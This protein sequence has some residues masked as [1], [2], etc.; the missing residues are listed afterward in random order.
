MGEFDAILRFSGRYPKIGDDAAVLDGGLLAATDVVVEA[1]HF[2]AGA[3]LDDVGWHAITVNVSDIAAMGGRA[4][5]VLVAVAGPAATDLDQL[6][7]GV[8]EACAEYGCE[9]AGG[10]LS[11]ADQLV[12]AVCALGYCDE[13]TTPVLRSGARSGDLVWVSGPLG[14]AAASGYAGRRRARTELGPALAAM[15]A[16]A[17][18]DVSDGLVQDLGH[19]CDAS[20]VG[21]ELDGVPVAPG[22][23]SDQ[24]LS[25]GDDYELLF[26]L[27]AG[28][29]P[30][31]CH[32]IGR[33]VSDARARPPAPPGWQHRFP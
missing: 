22:A 23:T 19:L 33:I 28:A 6:Y 18:I 5:H 1:V 11:N 20:G 21:A 26:T 4:R 32:R 13:G 27:P 24:A 8:D 25:G 3:S 12:V 10:D 7:A 31:G 2:A 30:P 9:V 14:A 16:T 17:M 29:D 15:G